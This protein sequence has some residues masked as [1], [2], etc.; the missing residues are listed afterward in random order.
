MMRR[1]L[2]MAVMVLGLAESAFG[3]VEVSVSVPM[4]A[5]RFTVAPPLVVVSPGIQVVEDY[6]EEVFFVDGWYWL[7]TDKRW[8]R[9]R[10]YD[11]RWVYIQSG[12]PHR[13]A[14]LP[15]GHYKRWKKGHG[16][17]AWKGPAH[18]VK[19]AKHH[20]KKKK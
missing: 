19:R 11:G 1:S 6:D 3:Q 17:H 20:G 15:P 7:R 8:Y 4:P 10:S 16:G 14:A 9:A 2:L 18:Q 5:V 13:L 12:V